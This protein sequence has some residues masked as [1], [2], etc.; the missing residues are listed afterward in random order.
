MVAAAKLSEE[1]NNFSSDEKE[2]LTILL[3]QYQLPVSAAFDKIKLVEMMQADKK[4]SS[5]TMNFIL[6]NK[7]GNAVVKPIGMQQLNHLV[8]QVL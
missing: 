7:I 4:R 2:K 5:G 8:E 6:L 3:Q 1:L